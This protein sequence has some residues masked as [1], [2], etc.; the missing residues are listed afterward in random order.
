MSSLARSQH[1]NCG[2]VAITL[3]QWKPFGGLLERLWSLFG[4]RKMTSGYHMEL[5]GLWTRA[6]DPLSQ[7]LPG[8][9]YTQFSQPRVWKT[10]QLPGLKWTSQPIFGT[11]LCTKDLSSLEFSDGRGLGSHI[12]VIYV[13]H[14]QKGNLS[15]DQD[16]TGSATSWQQI[17]AGLEIA[18]VWR[19]ALTVNVT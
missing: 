10:V 12:S 13:I 4:W 5:V 1:T 14:P 18:S 15:S 3:S 17:P 16:H 19:L 7:P 6:V 9:D 11:V 8:Q 2:H